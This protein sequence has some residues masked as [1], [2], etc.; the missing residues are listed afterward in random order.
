MLGIFRDGQIVKKQ[1]RAIGGH[2]HLQRDA[3]AVFHCAVARNIHIACPAQAHAG[4]ILTVQGGSRQERRRR[5]RRDC[6]KR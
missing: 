2:Q 6:V 5:P 3:C 4:R 1:H